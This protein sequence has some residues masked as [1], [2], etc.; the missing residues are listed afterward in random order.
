MP[1]TPPGQLGVTEGSHRS[2]PPDQPLPV[3]GG[4]DELAEKFSSTSIMYGLCRIQ[5]PGTGAHR[6]VLIN[7]VSAGLGGGSLS[8]LPPYP[9]SWGTG[10]R[11]GVPA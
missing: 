4:P 6:I 2:H 8:I 1:L 9:A 7:W 5:D 10:T 11:H 3:A